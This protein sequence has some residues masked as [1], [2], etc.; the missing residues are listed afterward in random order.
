MEYLAVAVPWRDL[1][2]ETDGS[3]AGKHRV[4]TRIVAPAMREATDAGAVDLWFHSFWDAAGRYEVPTLRAVCGTRDLPEVAAADVADALEAHGLDALDYDIDV[5]YDADRLRGY[6]GEQLDLW[7]EAKSRLSTLA[8]AAVEGDLGES[9]AFHRTVNRPGHVWANML[10][11]SYLAEAGVYTALARG[12]LR[13]LNL[14][15]GPQSRSVREAMTALDEAAAHLP[16]PMRELDTD[17]LAAV[18]ASGTRT[19]RTDDPE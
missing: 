13:M 1:A 17:E 2:A 11:C 18:N 8:V 7:T 3:L 16:D 9:Y 12:Y 10:G 19:P 4:L 5:A 14:G 6:W 15:E